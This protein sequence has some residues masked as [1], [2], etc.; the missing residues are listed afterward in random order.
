[1]REPNYDDIFAGD[2]TESYSDSQ[3]DERNL[4]YGGDLGQDAPAK[5][6]SP[7]PRCG[8]YCHGDCDAN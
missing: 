5:K 8:T 1:M 6:N 2:E 3:L 4:T 7:C